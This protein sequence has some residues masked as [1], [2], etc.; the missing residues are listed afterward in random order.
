MYIYRTYPCLHVYIGSY[1]FYIHVYIGGD[2]VCISVVVAPHFTFT[3]QN[4]QIHT[5]KQA[6]T[7]RH[8]ILFFIYG[9]AEIRKAPALHT[10]SL[11]HTQTQTHISSGLCLQK[12]LHPTVFFTKLSYQ[13]PFATEGSQRQRS[14]L[15]S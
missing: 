4:T 8:S 11:S 5:H 12:P 15:G 14:N 2:N 6:K 9:L 7:H 10:L 1:I 13:S 3:Y